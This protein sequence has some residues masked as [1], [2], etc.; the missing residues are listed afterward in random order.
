M[1]NETRIIN[2]V[3]F[4][5]KHLL[6]AISAED[7]AQAACLS[8]RHLY[9][10]FFDLTGD[11][12]MHYVRVRRLSLASKAIINEP[13]KTLLNIA[14]SH[15]FNSAEVFSRAFSRNFWLSPKTFKSIGSPYSATQRQRFEG[16]HYEIIQTSKLWQPKIIKKPASYMVGVC[17]TQPHYGFRVE[18]NSSEGESVS[19]KVFNNLHNIE[20]LV[21]TS[22]WNI[23]FRQSL[24]DQP[25]H[26]IRN[27]FAVRIARPGKIPDDLQCYHFPSNLYAVFTHESLT[28]PV[29]FT[30]SKAFDWL[31]RSDYSLGDAPSMFHRT[32]D[33]PFS[34]ELYIPISQ[35][36]IQS[37]YWWEGLY[38]PK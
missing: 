10:T 32:P 13:E 22:E 33:K 8:P 27:L 19:E 14:L 36:K 15:Q 37:L 35:Q 17:V 26:M 3:D 29:E 6:Q 1:L 11:N 38:Q 9:R 30:I 5:E 7:I 34:G 20:H 25:L 4:I 16:V 21:D 23:A 31:T 2:A 18:E 12:L 24:E 28:T